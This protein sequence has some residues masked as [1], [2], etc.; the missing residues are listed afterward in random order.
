MT[1]NV[2]IIIIIA[3]Y[4]LSKGNHVYTINY[5]LKCFQQKNSDDSNLVVKASEHY[6]IKQAKDDIEYKMIDSIDDI[7][8]LLK[9]I[10]SDDKQI[11][12]LIVKSNDLRELVFKLLNIG[13]EPQ[14]KKQAGKYHIYH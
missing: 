7:L 9:S 12:N 3:M 4:V 14:I 10:S 5:N 2:E 13:Y 11:I 6:Q 8:K 1:Q